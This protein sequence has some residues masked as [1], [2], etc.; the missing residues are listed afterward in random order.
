MREN[1]ESLKRRD[2]LR[3][4]AGLGVAGQALLPASALA[5]QAGQPVPASAA[6]PQLKMAD[7]YAKARQVLY[8][9]CR[10]CPQCDGVACA[11]E[12][13][14]IGGI[15]TGMSFQNNFTALKRVG[16]KLRT[17]TDVATVARK[18]DTSITLFGQKF[19]MPTF[20]APMGTGSTGSRLTPEVFLDA[21]LGG[22]VDAGTAG[23][24]GDSPFPPPEFKMRCDIIA[25]Y[26]GRGIMGVK[27][28][29]NANL[30]KVLPV[31]EASGAFLITIDVDSAARYAGQKPEMEVGTKTVAQ[32]RE[33]IRATKI[34]ILV[35][36]IMT[37]DEALMAGEAGAAGIV[38]SNHGG[39]VL[40]YTPGTAEVLPAIADAVKG[41]MPI[42]ADGCVHDGSDVLKYLALG[43]DAVM[44]G[45]HLLQ[46]AFGG[47]REGVALFMKVMRD[48][49]ET[50]MTMTGVPSVDKVSRRIIA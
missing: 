36:G 25:R 18:P 31:V 23:A 39:R 29:P 12:F 46:A 35:K 14:G 37:P 32:L 2:F 6:H 48:E 20:G 19:S 5:Q 7:V 9:V 41:K 26:H 47:G 24:I 13:P 42:L 38:V 27:P 28:R 40:D 17:L 50:A 8:P 1:D 10:V 16:L 11:G 33:V 4:S 30:L 45:R 43:A 44:V 34:P 3:A 22:C 15:G 21:L 49:L